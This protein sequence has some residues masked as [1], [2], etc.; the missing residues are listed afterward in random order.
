MDENTK[1]TG[2]QEHSSTLKIKV[3]VTSL[4]LGSL[5]LNL[6]ITGENT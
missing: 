5:Q 1:D 2:F 6:F 3:K 4:T